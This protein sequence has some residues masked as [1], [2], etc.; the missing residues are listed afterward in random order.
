MSAS[1]A[2]HKFQACI[3]Q[4]SLSRTLKSLC[5]IPLCKEHQ[6]RPR[7][8]ALIKES[9]APRRAPLL[10]QRC[11]GRAVVNIYTE[12]PDLYPSEEAAWERQSFPELQR[13]GRR[14]EPKAPEG[15]IQERGGSAS[16][17]ALLGSPASPSLGQPSSQ[18][19]G[20][21]CRL[22]PEPCKRPRPR[23]DSGRCPSGLNARDGISHWDSDVH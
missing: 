14:A 1:Q 5:S 8:C 15:R 22:P 21:A 7:S 12:F 20:R 4:V 18:E 9:S 16:R 19:V 11:S 6:Q 23:W 3:S 10:A 13:G 2:S 17:P